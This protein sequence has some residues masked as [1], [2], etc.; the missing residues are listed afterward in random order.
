MPSFFTGNIFYF[1]CRLSFIICICHVIL[2]LKQIKLLPHLFKWVGLT[3][4]LIG[5]VFGAIDDGR[6]GFMEGYNETQIENGHDPVEYEFVPIL[7]EEI[8]NLADHALLVGLLV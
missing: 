2:T 6:R 3:V 1:A 7:S 4:F 8:S 5:F